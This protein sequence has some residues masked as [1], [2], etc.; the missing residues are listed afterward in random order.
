MVSGLVEEVTSRNGVGK[1]RHVDIWIALFDEFL[2]WYISVLV[3]FY[4][5]RK[6]STANLTSYEKSVVV[7]LS[8][9]ISDSF[10]FRLLILNGYDVPARSPIPSF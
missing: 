8:K 5:E 6:S 4:A 2:A 1:S 10:A 7:I 9:L 3:V